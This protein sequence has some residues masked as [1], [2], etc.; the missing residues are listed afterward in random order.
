MSTAPAPAATPVAP[1]KPLRGEAP[2]VTGLLWGVTCVACVLALWFVATA[3]EAETRFI[4]PAMLP[5]PG[6]TAAKVPAV[7]GER[8]LLANTLV[9]LRRVCL[10]FGLSA[11]VGV[12]LGVLAACFPAV[13]SFVAPLTI[14]GRNIPVAALIPLT[15]FFFGIGEFQK[16]MFLFIASVA[17]VV[18]D[19][20]AAV[21]EVP[22][23]YVDTAL[24]LGASRLQ[25]ILKVLVP[26]AAPAIFNSLR[27]LF[28]I[29]FGYVMLAEVVKLGG[30]TGG[31]G[32]LIN[33]S[34][35]RGERE[36]I[37]IVLVVIPLVAYAI[38]R[39][40]WWLQCDLFPHRYGG[41]G[42]IPK[43]FRRLLHG[44]AARVEAGA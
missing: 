29:A 11:V 33:V 26:L 31:L 4:S 1:A 20:I 12:P 28:G 16:T 14:F 18:S 35:R 21:L 22:Q 3:G 8:R 5:S 10:G 39:L 25:I 37:L 30:D 13:R 41:R 32:D 42:T 40:L 43:L 24:T 23:R 44:A 6:E 17:F 9:T 2:A 38:D 34:Q 7:F 19:T 36:P 27:L 15:F